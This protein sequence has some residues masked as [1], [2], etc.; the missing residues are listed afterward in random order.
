LLDKPISL[1]MFMDYAN[2]RGS[3]RM[4]I[5]QQQRKRIEDPEQQAFRYYAPAVRSLPLAIASTD[6]EAV[7][8]AMLAQTTS[9]HQRQHHVELRDGMLTFIRKHHPSRV[10]VANGCQWVT[11]DLTVIIRQHMGI[12]MPDGSVFVVL[13][14]L[15]QPPLTQD[16]AN[17]GLRIIETQLPALLANG[18]P[19]VLDV[20]RARIFPLRRNANRR[21][22]DAWLRGEAAGY[23]AHW[24]AAA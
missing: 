8:D 3:G 19:R 1:P 10:P 5:V 18:L 24:A 14:Y 2:E 22:L 23:A 11:P 7:L 20:R 12:R 17:T 16:V 9:T 21:K 4:A 13:L 15:K 6:P